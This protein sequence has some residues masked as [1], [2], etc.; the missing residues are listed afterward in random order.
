MK[1][2]FTY[3]SVEHEDTTNYQGVV[4]LRDFGPWKKGTK[5]DFLSLEVEDVIVLTEWSVDGE[6]K[7][8]CNATLQEA[9]S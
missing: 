1:G 8:K 4:F 6:R 3:E 5:V 7:V 9:R 2:V